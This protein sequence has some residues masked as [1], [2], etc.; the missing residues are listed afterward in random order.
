MNQYLLKQLQEKIKSQSVNSL[1]NVYPDDLLEW[2]KITEEDLQKFIEFLHEEQVLAYKYRFYCVCG[3]VC[4]VYERK[5]DFQQKITCNSCGREHSFD[6]VKEK[7]EII[8]DLDKQEIL[9]LNNERVDFKEISF[10]HNKIVPIKLSDGEQEKMDE[11]YKI[12]IGSSTSVIPDME[13]IARII[14]DL[15]HEALPWNAKGKGLFVAG[16]YT[17][18]NLINIAGKV[19]AAIFMFNAE[20]QTWYS[21]KCDLKKEVRDNV[22]LEYGLFVGILGKENVTFICKDKPKIATDLLGLTYLNGNQ[23]EYQIKPELSDWIAQIKA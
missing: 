2:L 13:V 16:N 18:D 4:T 12:F 6:E 21:D 20:D 8:Y 14:D 23:T 10:R 9:E 7:S 1:G 19:D 11:K 15:G 22:L 3:E 17:W 5:M